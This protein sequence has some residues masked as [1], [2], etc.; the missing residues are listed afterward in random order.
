MKSDHL[1]IAGEKQPWNIVMFKRA[2]LHFFW[3]EFWSGFIFFS[4]SRQSRLLQ[5]TLEKV[6]SC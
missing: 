2:W 4:F 1:G 6:N 3:R 5:N